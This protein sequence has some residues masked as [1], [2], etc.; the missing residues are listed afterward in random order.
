MCPDPATT[1]SP[2]R[3]AVR[4]DQRILQ[5]AQEVLDELGPDASVEQI[6]ARAGVGVGS[7]YRRFPSKKAL[8][9]ALVHLVT[10]ELVRIG[11]DILA[12]DHDGRGL[13]TYLIRF[14]ETMVRHQRYAALML[15]RG[16]DE[17]VI[18]RIRGN[19]GALTRN[20]VAARV[21][22]EAVELGDVMALVWALRAII[23]TSAGVAPDAWRRFLELHLAALRPS[24]AAP[25]APAISAA[26]LARLARTRSTA[27]D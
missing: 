14:G 5:A 24:A 26:Q 9:D 4:N 8:V 18:A 10:E 12:Q 23:E 25:R 1:R 16:A 11:D 21:I 20:A 27:T 2:R 22:D 7:V 13:E 17:E 19:V 15:E 3:D 6:A